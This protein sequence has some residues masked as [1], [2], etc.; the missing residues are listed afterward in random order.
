MPIKIDMPML[1]PTMAKGNI[2]T[3]HKKEGDSIEVG[4]IVLDIDTDKATMEVEATYS[5]VLAKILVPA[6]T[7]DV[8]VKT[9]IAI[10]QQA[11]DSDDDIS[12]M[13]NNVVSGTIAKPLETQHSALS[14]GS[15]RTAGVTPNAAER[16]PDV[17]MQCNK[18]S[19]VRSSPLARKIANERGIDV[20]KI[21]GSGPGFRVVRADVE[22]IMTQQTSSGSDVQYVDTLPSQIRKVIAEKLTQSKQNIPHFYLS[23]SADV[24]ALIKMR[25]DINGGNV[26]DTKITVNDFVVKAVALAL[27]DHPEVNVAWCDGQVRSFKSIDIAVAVSVDDGLITPVVWDADSKSIIEISCEIKS[28]AQRAKS[29]S[30]TLRQITGGGI[31]VSN[32]GMHGI[33]HFFAIINHQQGSILSIGKARKVP[34]YNERNELVAAQILNI[35][36]SVDHRVIDGTVAAKFLQSLVSYLQTPVSLL[37]RQ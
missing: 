27:S 7:H 37:L 12:D 20:S 31:T 19:T 36:Y 10:L 26:I 22:K 29:K 8:P 35:G 15:D 23:V 16:V 2:V 6:G 5:G 25:E 34:M 13:V 30:L 4:D 9:A 17:S 3:W 11:G 18:I 1:S 21:V 32:L 33:D 14:T 28:L 24:T